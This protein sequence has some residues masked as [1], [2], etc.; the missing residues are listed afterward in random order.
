[1]FQMTPGIPNSRA[2]RRMRFTRGMHARRRRVLPYV[3]AVRCDKTAIKPSRIPFKSLRLAVL[4]CW[5]CGGR[6]NARLTFCA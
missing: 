5:I 4:S 6:D 2:I 3:R 1:M